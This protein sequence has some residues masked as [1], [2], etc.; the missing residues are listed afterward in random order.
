M[1]TGLHEILTTKAWF[2]EPSFVQ[3]VRKVL[4]L[5]LNTHLAFSPEDKTVAR[6]YSMD[7]KPIKEYTVSE[8]GH[9]RSSWD[10]DKMETPFVNVLTISGPVTRHGDVCSYGSIEHR[11]LMML[12]ADNENCKGHVFFLDT[13]GGSAFAIQ[14]YK[15]AIEYAKSKGQPVI[16]FIDGLCASAGMYIA[17]LC[18][19]RYYMNAKNE[20]GSIGVMAAF[21]TLADGAKNQFSDET[22]HEIYE[23]GSYDK[24][25]WYRDIAND[26][27]AQ[28]LMEQ[29]KT[30][31][32]E[33]RADVNAGCPSAP[34]AMLHGKLYTA[35]EATGTLVDGQSTLAETVMRCFAL[36]DGTAQPLER[37]INEEETS[38]DTEEEEGCKPKN[39]DD[40]NDGCKPKGE[41]GDDEGCKPKN[42]A[43]TPNNDDMNKYTE[44]AAACGIDELIVTEDGAH[45][46]ASL[47][48]ALE[49]KLAG[50]SE[51][52]SK[53][54]TTANEAM[55]SYKA[56]YEKDLADLNA[57][58]EELLASMQK[59][60]EAAQKDLEGA[61][62]ALATAEQQ[63][64]DKDAQIK[65]LT[66]K[67]AETPDQ[68]PASNGTSA[69]AHKIGTM[70]A[71]DST[72]S[73]MENAERRKAWLAS[74]NV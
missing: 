11:D 52:I 68:A 72:L 29:L 53:A 3:T 9:T 23:E 70:P 4:E 13:P 2:V 55:E 44:I 14:D 58:H 17:A 8:G 28:L 59:D 49:A 62:A 32:D 24:N 64:A 26:G 41:D 56:D 43:S 10:A 48:D 33:F 67:P 37:I 69:A 71:Y 15:Q 38:E 5:N 73:P 36:S 66:E 60:I 74:H 20:V 42:E 18:D 19:E 61:K 63:L 6:L 50:V 12:A 16:A 21:Y 25:K 27:D 39:E 54:E 40:S 7:A 45:M 57:K 47:L 34:D 46:D 31:G 30:L 1:I 35:A 51:E 65:T 22:F